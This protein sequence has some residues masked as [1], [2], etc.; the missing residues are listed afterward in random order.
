MYKLSKLAAGSVIATAAALGSA[1]VALADGYAPK[2]KV[3]YERPSDWSGVYFGVSSGY[4]WSDIN[5]NPVGNPAAGYNVTHDNGIAGGHIGVQHQFGAVVLGIEGN[6]ITAL[7][8]RDSQDVSCVN[9][10]FRCSARFNDVLTVGGRAGWAAGHWMPYVT[11]GYA[12]GA[13]QSTSTVTA[14]G[15]PFDQGRV[16]LNGWYLGGGVEWAVSPGWTAGL[17][18]RHYEYEARDFA[19]FTPAGALSG[20]VRH[21]DPSSDTV[22][23]RVSWKFGREYLA[24]L[25]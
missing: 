6:A 9:P 11:G 5:F 17:E 16:R 10:A 4:Q 24:P 7:R 20:D 12:N 25:K 1:G 21:M 15:L 23:A 13:F 22:T 8:E 19:L 18:Y 2:G 14:T 3:V